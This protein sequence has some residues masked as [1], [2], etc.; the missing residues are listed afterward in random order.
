M[1][2]TDKL[3]AIADAIR[4]KTGGTEELTLDQMVMEIAG[5]SGGGDEDVVKTI[6]ELTTVNFRH[7]TATQI[8]VDRL[9]RL[10]NNLESV[11]LPEVTEIIGS[12][13]FSTCT[14]LKNVQMPKLKLIDGMGNFENTALEEVVFPALYQFNNN[15]NFQNCTALRKIDFASK[16]AGN[17]NQYER[18]INQNTFKGCTSLEAVIIRAEDSIWKMGNVNN[19]A[20]SLIANGEGFIYVPASKIDEYRAA[21]NWSVYADQFRT[22]EGSEYE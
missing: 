12:F 16:T 17:L 11:E 19:F 5:I 2:L 9:F 14:A 15:A 20:D 13:I 10:N 4:G 6:L 1:A 22:I 3:I 21:T 7:D 18:N 8:H